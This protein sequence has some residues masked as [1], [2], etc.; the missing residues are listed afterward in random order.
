MLR[1]ERQSAECRVPIGSPPSGAQKRSPSRWS[2]VEVNQMLNQFADIF[3]Q[4]LTTETI[5][6]RKFR[7]IHLLILDQSVSRWGGGGLSNFFWVPKSMPSAAIAFFYPVNRVWSNQLPPNTLLG[8]EYHRN[9]VAA[10]ARAA[11]QFTS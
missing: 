8:L 7:T 4:I 1:A 5:K 9:A 10:A 6:I 2:G 11:P 3:L